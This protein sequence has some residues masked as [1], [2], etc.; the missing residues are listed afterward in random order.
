M[1]YEVL[2]TKKSRRRG[3]G[4]EKALVKRTQRREIGLFIDGTALDRATRRLNR[5]VNMAALVRGVT[6]GAT[7]IV[8]RYYTLIPFEDDSR[9]RAF[10]DAVA[11]AGLTVIVKRLPPKGNA[12]PVSVDLEMAAD[13]VAFA[14]GKSE[15]GNT[16]RYNPVSGTVGTG[17]NATE[18]PPSPSALP[19]G[20]TLRRG[21]GAET[22][23]LS[24]NGSEDQLQQLES[25]AVKASEPVKVHRI[26]TVVC[27]SRELAYPISLA[28]EYGVDTVTADFGMFNLGDMLKSA[29]KYTD[30]SD[31]ETIWR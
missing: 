21:I 26:I 12:R 5:K 18:E 8:A 6:S 15:F 20:L 27:P 23:Q 25:P 22:A 30:L 24:E 14:A 9:H 31:S 16:N 19:G 10:L 4:E 13:I 1:E 11:R 29:A 28:N 17:E 3:A 7:P 2:K